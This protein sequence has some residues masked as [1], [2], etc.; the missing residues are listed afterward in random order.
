LVR[1]SLH[2]TVPTADVLKMSNERTA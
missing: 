1:K 2:G